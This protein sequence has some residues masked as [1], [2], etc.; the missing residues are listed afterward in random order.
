[1]DAAQRLRRDSCEI[2]GHTQVLEEVSF[3]DLAY[4]SFERTMQEVHDFRIRLS[5]TSSET[6]I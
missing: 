6:P 5:Y 3:L 1:M 4:L 2:P